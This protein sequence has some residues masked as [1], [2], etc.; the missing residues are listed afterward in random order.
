MTRFPIR[1]HLADLQ[2]VVHGGAAQLVARGLD[3]STLDDFSATLLPIGVPPPVQ[4]ALAE[5]DPRAYPDPACTQLRAL[6][7][8]RHGLPPDRVLCANGSVALIRAVAQACLDV[9]EVGLIVGPTFGEYAAAVQA[10]GGVA[11]TVR[12]ESVDAVQAAIAT[13]RPALVFLCN[14]N[15][16]TGFRWRAPDLDAI[17][18]LAP[19]VIDEAYMGFQRPV[20]APATGPGRLVLRSL[21][22]D[23]ALAGLR[24]G[25]AIGPT[26]LVAVLG[27]L[28]VPWGVNALAQAAALAA[29]RHPDAYRPAIDALWAERDRLVSAIRAA[30]HP[31]RAGSAP[32]FLVEVGDAAHASAALLA[33]GIVVR[34]CTSFGLPRHIRISP[35]DHA[36]GDRLL[37]ALAEYRAT[38]PAR[39][40]DRGPSAAG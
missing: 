25:Y 28:L 3:P 15:N 33:A 7:A 20:P 22:K 1:P 37:A 26:D 14:P 11:V 31:V 39:R 38:P 2:P 12:T 23:H 8:E 21:T 16:P 29:L 40:A 27:N 5:A 19:L 13:H 32:Y 36:A 9:G 24:V 30:G 18:A 4:R 17:A 10:V 34:D 35:Q 6:L